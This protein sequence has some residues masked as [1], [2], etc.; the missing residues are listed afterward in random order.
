M[1]DAINSDETVDGSNLP[2]FDGSEDGLHQLA[3]INKHFTDYRGILS[4]IKYGL[5]PTFKVNRNEESDSSSSLD[6]SSSSSSSDTSTSKSA[7]EYA[8]E[9]AMKWMIEGDDIENHDEATN[10]SE[11]ESIECYQRL[12]NHL[13][14]PHHHHLRPHQ[15]LHHPHLKLLVHL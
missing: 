4:L 3:S 14:H 12:M 1:D 8:R 6:A 7:I 15:L 13:T 10:R 9:A 5:D 2:F 11:S